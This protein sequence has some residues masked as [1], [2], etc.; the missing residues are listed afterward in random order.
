MFHEITR[1]TPLRI[2]I[3]APILVA[4]LI[5]CESDAPP[6]PAPRPSATPAPSPTLIS[7]VAATPTSQATPV[8][9][10]TPSPTPIPT[11]TPAPPQPS[12]ETD[13]EALVALYNATDG[14]N[15]E[16]NENWLTDA[17]IGEWSGVTTNSDG[18]VS[19]LN[20][21]S[22]GLNGEIPPELGNLTDLRNTRD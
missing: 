16:T 5:S 9:S 3:L 7:T 17:P 12:A 22:G 18:R 6:T 20:L 2:L 4:I 21:H 11:V 8:P 1:L 15:W 10:P 14:P 13:R 19:E